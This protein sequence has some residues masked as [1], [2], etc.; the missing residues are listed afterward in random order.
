MTRAVFFMP[1]ARVEVT[2]AQDWYESRA[3]GLGA[4]FR[5]EVERAVE[6]LAEGPAHFP[7]V[8]RDVRRARLR[9]FPYALHFRPMPDGVHVIAC[10]HSRR[11]PLALQR[12]D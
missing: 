10:F 4:A 7:T 11:D 12:R 6:R 2:E 3:K 5:R 9:R 1:A 8:L